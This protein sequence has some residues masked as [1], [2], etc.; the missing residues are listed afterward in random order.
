[1][2]Q[3]RVLRACFLLVRFSTKKP[4]LEAVEQN[5]LASSKNNDNN[6]IYNYRRVYIFFLSA[7]R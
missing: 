5:A 6:K 4:P 3:A 7:C 2:Y 1:M